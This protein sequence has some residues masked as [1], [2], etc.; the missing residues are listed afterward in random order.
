MNVEVLL[1]IILEKL[2][3]FDLIHQYMC[4]YYK[5]VNNNF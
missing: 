5:H 1:S 4:I 3:K 2:L